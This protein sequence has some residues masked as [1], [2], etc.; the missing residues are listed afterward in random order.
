MS[1]PIQLQNFVNDFDLGCGFFSAEH[2]IQ[3]HQLYMYVRTSNEN[4]I[5]DLVFHAHA[6]SIESS[7]P[8]LPEAI[9]SICM[10]KCNDAYSGSVYVRNVM[11]PRG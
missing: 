4:A 3:A 1:Q 9:L 5:I 6:M 11:S 8:M 7:A 2:N 10:Y